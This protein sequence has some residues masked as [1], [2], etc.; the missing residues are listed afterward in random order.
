[1]IF[2]AP[3]TKGGVGKSTWQN[4][5]FSTYLHLKSNEKVRLI[6]I[7]DENEDSIVF[8][9]TDILDAEIIPT[10]DIKKLDEIFYEEDEIV[11]DIGGNKT[12]KTLLK[13]LSKM[14]KFDNVTWFIPMGSGEMDSTNALE[15]YE[16]ITKMD[17][18]P[19]IIFVLSNAKT[20]DKE[21]EF[22]NFFGSDVID[23]DFA[24]KDHIPNA[25]YVLVKH[26]TVINHARFLHKT[27]F[28]LAQD[29]TDYRE[30]AAEAKKGERAKPLAL[31][32]LKLEAI[33]YLDYLK[34]DVYPKLDELL[35]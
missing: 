1:M 15:M 35:K 25:E 26:S 33:E 29:E 14:K 21:W 19:K 27:F 17:K 34:D 22:M 10:S 8:T 4:Q 24:I 18:N 16:I 9:K 30:L 28:D 7:D 2:L 12:S 32:R 20:N 11:I 6:E 3:S 31:N 23:I 5:I 13:S